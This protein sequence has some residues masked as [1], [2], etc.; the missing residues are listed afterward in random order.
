MQKS[1]FPSAPIAALFS[2]LPDD[3]KEPLNLDPHFLAEDQ[4]AVVPAIGTEFS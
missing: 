1:A 2:R 3:Q 4:Q